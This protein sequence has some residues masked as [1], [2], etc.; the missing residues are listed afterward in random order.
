MNY[1]LVVY[2]ALIVNTFLAVLFPTQ[3]GLGD[4]LGIEEIR[5]QQFQSFDANT[6]SY[7]VEQGVFNADGT[8]GEQF[9]KM[10]ELAKSTEGEGGAIVTSLGFGFLDYLLIPTL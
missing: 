7:F 9:S 3:L 4:P 2:M 10:E 1:T 6:Q 5:Q 8:P